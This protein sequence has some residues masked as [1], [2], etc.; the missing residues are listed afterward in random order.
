MSVAVTETP[1]SVGVT[2]L[3]TEVISHLVSSES[4]DSTSGNETSSVNGKD[5]ATRR[6]SSPS[7]LIRQLTVTLPFTVALS[8]DT[9]SV[10][11]SK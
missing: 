9:S 2:A 7:F 1:S 4:K 10:S 6:G 8:S 11:R 3:L 5:L